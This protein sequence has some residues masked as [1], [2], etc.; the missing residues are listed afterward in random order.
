V[1]KPAVLKEGDRVAIVSP[2]TSLPSI[3]PAV[4][5]RGIENLRKYFGLVPVIAEHAYSDIE[6]NYLHP[7]M[8]A[9][10]LNE[11]YGDRSIKAIISTIGGDESVRILRYLDAAT[12]SENPKIFTGFSDCTTVTSYLFNR[13]IASIYGGAVMA[14]FAQMEHFPK[15]FRDYWYRI[16]FEDSRNLRMEGFHEFS[17]GYPDWRSSTEASAISKKQHAEEWKWINGDSMKGRIFAAN[18]EVLDSLRGTDHF[19]LKEY[20]KGHMLL[21]ETS[22]EVPKPLQVAR[23]I[24]NF[25]VTGILDTVTGIGLGRYRGY[26]GDMKMEVR[27]RIADVLRKEFGLED[28]PFVDGLDFGHTDPYFPLPVGIKA[29]IEGN[30]IT[31]LESF[32]TP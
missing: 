2:S 5:D 6:H 16:M 9:R 27:A 28:L 12:I 20:L 29:H 4:A 22:E 19:P 26:S 31:F 18:L 15:E 1:K 14:G 23:T 7:E 13:N 3:F 21:L 30:S 17:E 24:R 8:R 32:A 25:A 10:D 11:A